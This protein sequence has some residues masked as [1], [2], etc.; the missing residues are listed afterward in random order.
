MLFTALTYG[1]RIY[2]RAKDPRHRH[3][4]MMAMLCI[5]IISVMQ[6]INDLLETDKVGPFFF[7]SLAMLINI[8]LRERQLEPEAQT[9]VDAPQA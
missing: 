7:M 3:I 1:E 5:I 4:A 6:L 2:H 8:D 9:E